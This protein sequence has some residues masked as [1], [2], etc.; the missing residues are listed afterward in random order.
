MKLWHFN[1]SV[2]AYTILSYIEYG[3][4]KLSMELWHFNTSVP[5]L[6]EN[7]QMQ[8]S[9]EGGGGRVAPGFVMKE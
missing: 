2:H 7:A 9:G 3:K 6:G 1:T 5:S 4:K 8:G